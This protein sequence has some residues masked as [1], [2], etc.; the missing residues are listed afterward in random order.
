MLMG[1][2]TNF[3]PG[4]GRDVF[5]FSLFFILALSPL[6]AQR[7]ECGTRDPGEV[8]IQQRRELLTTIRR[9]SK[10]ARLESAS[11]YIAVRFH[12]VRKSNGN[13]G[14]TLTQLNAVFAKM[15]AAYQA[16]GIQFYMAG[17]TPHYIDSDNFY[18]FEFSEE[19]ALTQGNDITN[20]INV[21]VVGAIGSGSGSVS[22]YAYYPST[23]AISNR[24]FMT[25][26][27][28]A[29]GRSLVHEL[30][31][32]FNLLHTFHNNANPNVSL[33]ELVTRSAGAN[34]TTAGDQVCDTPADPYGLPG[35]TTAGC[36]YTGTA[37]D[38]NGAVFVPS[39]QNTMSYYS[40]CGSIFTPQQYTR[41]SD[42]LLLRTNPGNEYTLDYPTSSAVPTQLTAT[43]NA[44][45]VL[46]S[47]VDN[48]ADES[49]FL[50]ERATNSSGPFTPIAGLSPNTTTYQDAAVTNNTLYHYRIR[51]T[52]G[53]QYS[54]VDTAMVDLFYCKP[55]YSS[56]CSPVFIADFILSQNST[57]LV[58]KINSGCGV[59]GY[60]DFTATALPV[61]AGQSYNFTARAVS[62]GTGSY[63][64]QHLTIW[65]DFN[66]NGV[67]EG[68]EAAYQSSAGSSLSPTVS[69]SFS[70]PARATPGLTRMR[71]RSQY[72]DN[73]VVTNPC[74][75]LQ[76]GEAEDYTLQINGNIPPPLVTLQLKVYLEGAYRTNTGAMITALNQRGLLP[77]QTPVGTS[78]TATPPGQPYSASPWFYAGTESVASYQADVVDWVLVS[79]REGAPSVQS[80][81]YRAAALVKASG[82]IITVGTPPA[83]SAGHSYYIAIEHRNHLGVLSHAPVSASNGVL[84]YD[85]AIQNSYTAT[86]PVSVGQKQIG[87]VF[88][89]HSSDGNK[90][91]PNQDFVVNVNDYSLWLNNN[92]WFDLYSA[93]DFNM[94]AQISASDKAQWNANNSKFS[95]VGRQ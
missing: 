30:G 38:A 65:I 94:D 21:Y 1:Y 75:M 16:S 12:V 80:T 34:C 37:T 78:A 53:I 35:A 3:L 24:V 61:T 62:G 56:P 47:F 92:G 23:L 68:T 39:L 51:V 73:G 11:T 22:G 93:A 69:S 5:F 8:E 15:N 32:Y 58:S 43:K 42:G 10:E 67:F 26:D 14:V 72:Y 17:T 95:M 91:L 41:L 84:S 55:S 85:F 63:F 88:A 48:I 19:N 59:A 20:A 2:S 66:K 36:S 45:G 46:V 25:V 28:L 82:E 89:M 79:L 50:V 40:Q 33:R 90:T 27:A 52:N 83:L 71:V 31:H 49:G 87:T 4:R 77:G 86:S 44:G 76:F 60:S 6:H 7:M 18:D 9:Y 13:Q 64:P 70:I 29:D 57:N 81:V 74:G 54:A